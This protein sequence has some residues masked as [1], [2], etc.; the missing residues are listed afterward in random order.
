[1]QGI[2]FS[3][4]TSMRNTCETGL[5]GENEHVARTSWCLQTA[6]LMWFDYTNALK[7]QH[8]WLPSLLTPNTQSCI[9]LVY[10]NIHQSIGSGISRV[11]YGRLWFFW[12]LFAHSE[13]DSLATL[14]ECKFPEKEL[15]STCLDFSSPLWLWSLWR[16]LTFSHFRCQSQY[17]YLWMFLS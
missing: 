14:G 13:F 17:V 12:F 6:D 8:L 10:P 9:T 15:T 2:Y 5:L 16:I 4:H 3:F 11:F 7:Q 1:M